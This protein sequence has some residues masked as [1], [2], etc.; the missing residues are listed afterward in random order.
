[1]GVR[2]EVPMNRSMADDIRGTGIKHVFIT[3]VNIIRRRVLTTFVASLE[4]LLAS[5]DGSFRVPP[6]RRKSG[7]RRN[8]V[9]VVAPVDRNERD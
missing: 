4:V 1:M 2:H 8:P 5:L 6:A 9:S 7:L 3:Y